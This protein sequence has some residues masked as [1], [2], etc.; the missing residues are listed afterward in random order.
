MPKG[1]A[2]NWKRIKEKVLLANDRIRAHIRETPL[3]HSPFLSECGNCQVFLK[4]E[5]EQK[6][7]SFKFR[8]ALNRVLSLSEEEKRR[9]VVT[10]STGNHGAAMA[11]V[12]TDLGITGKIFMPTT[13]SPAKVE[14]LR[15]LG[16]SVEYSGEDCVEAERAAR[17]TAKNLGVTFVSPYNDPEIV[18]GQ[19]TVGLEID[20]KLKDP[21]AILTPVGGGGLMSGIAAYFKS[22]DPLVEQIGCQPL[23]SA[24]M[25]ES[26][27]AGRILELESMPT[28]SDGTAG[29]IEPGS[30]TFEICR[31]TVADFI[32][33]SESEISNAVRTLIE[34]HHILVE[35]AGA[36][37]TA[38]FL[39]DPK[40]FSGRTVVLVVSGARISLDE[41]RSIL[42]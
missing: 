38:S 1:E 14:V 39:Q 30:I 7:R 17:N 18:A 12:L 37:S 35:G 42:C 9:G 10:A 41:L 27:K 16:A 22:V 33:V 23:N 31:K 20:R 21:Q 32:I 5:N 15:L 2:M 26:V 29:G 40:R 11:H 24:V 6:T 28:L 8:G 4:L 3:E 13:A 19:G 34:R 36:L 25:Y